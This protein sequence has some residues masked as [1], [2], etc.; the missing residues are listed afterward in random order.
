METTKEIK[1]Q[2]ISSPLSLGEGQG[3]RL[4][5]PSQSPLPDSPSLHCVYA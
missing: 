4:L 5:T 1:A 3:V 2:N